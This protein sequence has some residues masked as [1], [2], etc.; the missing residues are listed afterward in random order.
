MEDVSQR[1]EARWERL[2]A[3]AREADLPERC[4]RSL[5]KARRV[6]GDLLATIGFFFATVQAKIE[7]LNLAPEIEDVAYRY[8]IPAIDL[9]QVAD[10]TKDAEQRRQLRR[11]VTDLLDSA[12]QNEALSRLRDDERRV[13]DHV[14]VECTG[15][16]QRGSSRVEGRNGQLALH[17]HARHRPSNRKLAALTAVHNDYIR[18]PDGT[19]AAERFFGRKSSLLFDPPAGRAGTLLGKVPLPGRPAR[20][21]PRPPKPPYLRP[22]AA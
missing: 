4:L 11:R 9:D 13:L 7:A 15:L 12:E 14:A 6:T 18:R 5:R 17:H 1:L 3:L 16:F 22:L 20:K 19:T 21:R 2:N 8:R 10:K